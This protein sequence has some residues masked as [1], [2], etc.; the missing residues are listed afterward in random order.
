MKESDINVSDGNHNLTANYDKLARSAGILHLLIVP[1]GIFSFV[2]I[3]LKLIAINDITLTIDNVSENVILFRL[4][5][6]SHLLSQVLV[7]FLA[8]SL[9]QLLKNVNQNRARLMLIFALL[10][11]PISFL[12]EVHNFQIIKLIE[13]E[14]NGFLTGEL[15]TLVS[16]LLDTSRN[17][18]LISQIFWGL[19]LLPLGLL[20]HESAY[21]P[22]LIGLFVIVAG[23]AYV[24][25]SI[26][27]LLSPG[28]II[29]SKYT[30][31]LEL[32]F[33]IWLLVKGVKT[34]NT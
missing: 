25:D 17:G 2:Y 21:V 18:V 10:V 3:P 20:I 11:V 22:K 32:T 9:Y 5:S 16:F 7:V 15:S 19:W 30:F 24:F 12:N 31:I 29:I 28:F 34:S 27:Q 14:G 4:G 6:I 33:P 1:L 26:A 8:L 23:L 13:N